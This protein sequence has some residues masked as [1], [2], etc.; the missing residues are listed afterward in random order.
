MHLEQPARLVLDDLQDA[1]AEM[2][3]H[4]L[5]HHRADPLDQP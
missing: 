2:S 1:G 4:P 3:H 5:G